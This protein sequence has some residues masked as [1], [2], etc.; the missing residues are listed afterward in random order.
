[1]KKTAFFI[2]IIFIG[3]IHLH[4]QQ[5]GQNKIQHHNL[6]WK[7]TETMHCRIYYYQG[8]DDL[9]YFAAEVC[10]DAYK[11]LSEHYTY[12][13]TKKIPILI[14]KSP[15]DFSETNITLELLSESVGGFTE[16]LKGRVVCPFNGSYEDFRHVLHHE[17]THAFQFDILYGGTNLFFKGYLM[18]IPLWFT[19]GMAEWESRG[20]D[21]NADMYIRDLLYSEKLIPLTELGNWGGYIIY[22]EGQSV[23]HFI[24]EKYGEEKIGELFF[25]I[26]ST[27][28]LA[29][30]IEKC[31]RVDFRTFNEQWLEFIN[32]TY[33]PLYNDYEN[34][35]NLSL[36]LTDTE[37]DNN[38]MNL[39][40]EISPDGNDIVFISDLGIYF[41]VFLM[42]SF[43]G[44]IERKL[45]GGQRTPQFEGFH[46]LRSGLSWSPDNSKIIISSLSEGQDLLWIINKSSGKIEKKLDFDL[47]IVLSPY[48][49][50]QNMIYFEGTIDGKTDIYRTDPQGSFLEK[51]TDDLYDDKDPSVS[52]DG[53]YLLWVSDRND[54]SL[55][56]YGEYAVFMMELETGEYKRITPVSNYCSNPKFINSSNNKIL[57]LA[58][59]SSG[60]NL[61]LKDIES[62]ILSQ[63]TN[64]KGELVSFSIDYEGERMA[65]CAYNGGKWDVFTVEDPLEILE[66]FE[67][68][69]TGTNDSFDYYHSVVEFQDE[70]LE[71]EKPGMEISAD[72][73]QA[74][75]A[76]SSLFGFAGIFTIAFSDFLGNNR[77]IIQSDLSQD[78]L[79]SNFNFL[80]YYL[81]KRWDIGFGIYQQKYA[82][83]ETTDTV[84]SDI[85]AGIGLLLRYPFNR[86]QRV[87][88]N[89]D[90]YRQYR[91]EYYYNKEENNF[92]FTNDKVEYF[93]A[94]SIYYVSDNTIWGY[95]SPFIGSRMRIGMGFSQNFTN[96]NNYYY[97]SFDYRKYWRVTPR[98]NIA[99]RFYT[100]AI[101]GTDPPNLY[102]GGSNNLRGYKINEFGGKNIAFINLEARFPFM[103][104]LEVIFPLPLFLNNIR[105]CMFTDIGLVSSDLNSCKPFSNREEGGWGLEDLKLDFGLGV[106]MFFWTA[107]LKFDIAL[108]TDL[109]S[110]SDKSRIYFSIGEDF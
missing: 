59:Y 76:Y 44:I 14:Y 102:I 28:S 91:K 5:F 83:W 87:D 26:K 31:L 25:D 105:G 62:D 106:R 56:G 70:D 64:V 24:A 69:N 10:E 57:F 39:S 97:G 67:V 71:W 35:E 55:W 78:I 40:P 3:F 99:F 37:K 20:W 34:F 38:Y 72:W 61:Y 96:K 41:E 16:F 108:P 22:K 104:N 7:V 110:F 109:R 93:A 32:S 13:F 66:P 27:G 95:T 75:M 51:I 79:N 33:F 90:A 94:P 58:S 80:Y 74:S 68:N 19:E 36:R 60:K 21:N 47:D 82:F 18:D 85:Y 101:R 103:D 65:V 50:H 54:D 2:I 49:S 77:F 30:A 4:S 107:V 46:I 15:N 84:N 88:I 73:G 45:I 6:D 53:E 43:T 98:S 100:A 48:W 12:E 9:A 42:S 23:F 52:I 89:L 81:P 63:L 8:M 11:S 29:K 17:L 86:Y 1:M 92:T